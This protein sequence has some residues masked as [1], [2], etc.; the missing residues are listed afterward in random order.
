[1]VERVY[2]DV[3]YVYDDVTYV[4]DDVTYDISSYNNR[5]TFAVW[6]SV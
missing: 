1:M 2:D 4:Y 6:L 3:T 5:Y